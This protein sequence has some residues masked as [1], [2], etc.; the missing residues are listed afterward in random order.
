[1]NSGWWKLLVGILIGTL[2]PSLIAWGSMSARIETNTDDIKYKVNTSV[3]EEYK[4]G[5][6]E[7]L[8]QIYNSL[9][10]IEHKIDKR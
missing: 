4:K 2:G 1:M 8:K 5:N 6:T 7:L 9:E 10:R 3:F